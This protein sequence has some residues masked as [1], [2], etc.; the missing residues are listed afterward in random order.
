MQSGF[1]KSIS[2]VHYHFFGFCMVCMMTMCN[3]YYWFVAIE[4]KYIN[5]AC[6]QERKGLVTMCGLNGP[7]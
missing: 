4:A 2:V 6:A 3:L 7:K 5:C 1:D